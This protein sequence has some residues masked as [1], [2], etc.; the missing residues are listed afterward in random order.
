M[1]ERIYKRRLFFITWEILL[2]WFLWVLFG[3]LTNENLSENSRYIKKDFTHFKGE[4]YTLLLI[5]YYFY[6]FQ[7]FSRIFFGV[8]I[9]N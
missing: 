1:E 2:F 3:S 9:Q 6:L 5:K 8:V 4:F 7:Y